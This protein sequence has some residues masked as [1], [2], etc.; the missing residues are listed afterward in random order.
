MA[1][2]IRFVILPKNGARWYSMD[3]ETGGFDDRTARELVNSITAIDADNEK[4]IIGRTEDKPACDCANCYSYVR[5]TN[6]LFGNEDFRM[7]V[8]EIC[9]FRET[10]AGGLFTVGIKKPHQFDSI[11]KCIPIYVNHISDLQLYKSP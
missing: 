4:I 6:L 2:Y 8:D 9:R 1:S 3:L 5:I 7:W 10:M 11:V